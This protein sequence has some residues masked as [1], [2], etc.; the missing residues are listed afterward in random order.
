MNKKI[1]TMGFAAAVLFAVNC[2]PKAAAGA[3]AGKSTKWDCKFTGDY[4]EKDGSPGK[5]TWNVVWTETGDTSVLTGTGKD[6][7]GDSTANGTCEKHDCKVQEEY[8]SGSM[9]GKK[10]YWAFSYVDAETKDEKVFVTT[11]K[12]TYG[13]SE[14]DRASL[15]ALTAKADCKAMQ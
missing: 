9:K 1:A 7:G 6:E 8:T 3:E 12:G 10:G 13:P 5:F 15:G 11:L 4:K 14:T 2:K